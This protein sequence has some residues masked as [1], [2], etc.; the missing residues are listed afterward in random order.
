MGE[1]PNDEGL[2]R[3]HILNAVEASL[4][5]LQID[6][7]DLYQVHWPDEDT[8]I[9][10]T[11]GALGD[12]VRAGSVRYIGCSNY[13]AWRL[14]QALWTSDARNLAR[15]D[16]L[17]PHY[18]LVHRQEY[19]RELEAVCQT[20]GLGVIPYSPLAGGYLTGKYQRGKTPP[21]SSRGEMSNRIQAYMQDDQCWA[22]IEELSSQANKHDCSISQVALAWILERPSITS[23]IIGPR[24]IA[25]LEDNLGAIGIQLSAGDIDNL[26][27]SSNK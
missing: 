27:K 8:P 5:R 15:F 12:L 1:G 4:R 26:E 16:C 9:E 25:Q 23:A 10:E 13:P 7:I 11:L 18:N 22:V 2:S 17:Q 14:M 19:E 3:R 6:T 20:Y 21:K 24:S